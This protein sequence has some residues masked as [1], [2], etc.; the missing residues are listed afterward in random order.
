MIKSK[1]TIILK[2]SFLNLLG[3]LCSG[4]RCNIGIGCTCSKLEVVEKF[5]VVRKEIPFPIY[6]II[7]TST[8]GC[9]ELHLL[10]LVYL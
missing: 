3:Y 2:M 4:N 5:E 9:G 7:D 1:G 8:Y 10:M 6:S